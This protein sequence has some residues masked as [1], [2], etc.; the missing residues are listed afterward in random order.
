MSSLS[1]EE[2]DDDEANEVVADDDIES[3]AEIFAMKKRAQLTA[4]LLLGRPEVGVWALKH[5]WSDANG[6][7]ELKILISSNDS[8]A[9]SIASEIV[10][11]ASSVESARPFLSTLVEEGTLED[12]LIHPDADVRSGAASCM[13]KIGLGSKSLSTDEGE[14]MELLDVAIELLFEEGE[15]NF[16]DGTRQL[17]KQSSS[18]KVTVESTAMDRGVEVLAYLV[19]KT[20]I[21]EKIAIGYVPD[22]SPTNRKSALQRLVEIAC[23]LSDGDSQIAYGLAGI[24]NLIAVSI[25]TLRKE[26]FIGKEITQEQYDQLQALGKTEEEKAAAKNDKKEGDNTASVRERIQKLANANVPM[27]LVKLLEGSSSDA[28][29]EKVLEGMGRM[30]SEPVVSLFNEISRIWAHIFSLAPSQFL[31]FHDIE[32]VRAICTWYDDPAGVPRDVPSAR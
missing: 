26:A 4:S 24:F 17:A 27:A 22:G 20:F 13:A 5:G 12:L 6:L 30:A 31:L 19:S 7:K 25:E 8:R 15:D 32:G 1:I 21:K 3:A 10:S 23:G 29:Q 28:A 9:M 2:L 14:V 18:S 16:M 11:A